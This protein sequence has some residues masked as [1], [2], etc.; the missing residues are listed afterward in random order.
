[1]RNKLKKFLAAIV[2]TILVIGYY[3]WMFPAWNRL[4]EPTEGKGAF[5]F[6]GVT[7]LD[8]EES[9]VL[10]PNKVVFMEGELPIRKINVYIDVSTGAEYDIPDEVVEEFKNDFGSNAKALHLYRERNTQ[11]T[12]TISDDEVEKFLKDFPDAEPVT[13]IK[14]ANGAERDFTQAELATIPSSAYAKTVACSISTEDVKPQNVAPRKKYPSPPKKSKVQAVE[15]PMP[16]STYFIAYPRHKCD[17]VLAINTAKGASYVIKLVDVQ[18][19]EDFLTYFLPGGVRRE[20]DV[21][22]GDFELRY[23]CGTRW[24]GVEKLFGPNAAYVKADCVFYFRE[25]SGYEVTLYGVKDG[26]LRTIAISGED[27]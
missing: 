13:R 2:V 17:S 9:P 25:G 20:I 11:K 16:Q 6:D 10:A 27:F 22:S 12:Y 18:N 5:A 23:T 21:P 15:Y 19:E 7:I 8:E 3:S 4:N 26:N 1:M 14:L 24:Y